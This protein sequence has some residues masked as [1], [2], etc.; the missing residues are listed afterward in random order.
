MI[1]DV[2]LYRN[3]D[4]S[5]QRESDHLYIVAAFAL[6]A[7]AF[8]TAENPANLDRL[9]FS[10]YLPILCLWAGWN[11]TRPVVSGR[12]RFP[13]HANA[14]V[15]A[16]PGL[17]CC[18]PVGKLALAYGTVP[19]LTA[20]IITVGDLNRALWTTAFLVL[21][22]TAAHTLLGV[23]LALTNR[24]AYVAGLVYVLGVEL[25]A[26]QHFSAAA[27][28]SISAWARSATGTTTP[29][30]ILV[31]W[32]LLAVFTALSL[33]WTWVLLGGSGHKTWRDDNSVRFGTGS[34]E[35]S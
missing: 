13:K 9:A 19:A 35:S 28:F 11:D 32:A 23:T 15:R 24:I 6:V 4:M 31:A 22:T 8:S 26:A 10:T 25:L 14:F 27:W 7:Y 18:L 3:R 34:G 1:T 20:A 30:P 16:F 33:L 5:R 12:V 29:I 17:M 2:T 21:L